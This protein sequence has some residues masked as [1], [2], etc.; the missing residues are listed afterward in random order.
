MK[1]TLDHNVIIDMAHG[2]ANVARLR[3]ILVGTD[4]EA[5]VVEIGASEMR[6]RGIRPDRYDLF[7]ELL[8][9]AGV[10]SLPRLT[11]MMI[12]DVTFWDHCLWSDESMVE[13]ATRIDRILF[14]QSPAIDIAAEQQ[15]SPKYAAWLNR[16]CDVHTMWCHLHYKNDVFVT[17]D[18]NFHKKTKMPHLVSLG[19]GRICKPELL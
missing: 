11:P 13:L 12:W 8:N 7:E 2:N 3:E 18:Q 6:K 15:D 14:G 9:E 17:S 16:V 1:L 10:G 5:Y 19:A 4:H